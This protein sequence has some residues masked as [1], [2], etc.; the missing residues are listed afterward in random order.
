MYRRL[1]KRE[2]SGGI[3]PSPLEVKYRSYQ[4]SCIDR[5]APPFRRC[6]MNTANK[7]LLC[8]AD[9]KR[10][11]NIC[12]LFSSAFAGER[13]NAGAL[14]T[15][16]PR[17]RCWDW[18]NIRVAP[19]LPSATLKLPPLWRLSPAAISDPNLDRWFRQRRHEDPPPAKPAANPANRISAPLT[20]LGLDLIELQ[21][22]ERY[23]TSELSHRPHGRRP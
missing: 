12:G 17:D 9:L 15:C 18:D 6:W 23:A 16:P 22:R 21:R 8:A 11:A 4:S 7:R 20:Q 19:S 10:L 2:L 5:T 3:R 1:I 13:A 14:A